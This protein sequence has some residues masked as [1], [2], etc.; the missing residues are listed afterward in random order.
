MGHFSVCYH[1]LRTLYGGGVVRDEIF[2]VIGFMKHSF[3]VNKS[4]QSSYGL[5]N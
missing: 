2:P 1:H 4:P 5:I 3:L